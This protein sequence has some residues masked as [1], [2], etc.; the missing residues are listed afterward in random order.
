MPVRAVIFDL[1][2]TLVGDSVGRVYEEPRRRLRTRLVREALA[3]AGRLYSEDALTSALESFQEKHT[4]LHAESR[5]IAA[6]ERVE[7]FL[8]QLR[9]GVAGSLTAEELR[10]VEDALV[11]PGRLVP[12]DPAPGAQEV[13]K[14]A[15]NRGLRLGLISNAGITPGYVLRLLLAEH[16]LLPYLQV[17]TFSDEARMAKPAAG[18]FRCTLDA[19]DVAPQEAVFVGDMPELDVAGPLAVGMWAVQVGDRQMDGV[20]PHGRVDSLSELLPELERMGLL[21]G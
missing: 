17:L 8:R 14:E 2:G 9:P 12:P 21:G 6:P 16:G 15:K 7:L 4:A 5:D 11:T 19:L 10:R 1:W 18:M 13:L 20:N 3:S